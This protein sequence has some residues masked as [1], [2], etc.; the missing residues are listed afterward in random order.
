MRNKKTVLLTNDD[1]FH[2]PGIKSLYD[3]FSKD[4]DVIAVAPDKEQSGVGHTFTF[5][6][7]LHYREAL[8]GEQMPGYL[9]S[10]SPAD[11]VKFAISFLLP[12]RPDIVI[13]GMN[14]GDNS[15]LS[16]FYSGTVAAAREGAFWSIPSFAFSMCSGG[17]SY[18]NQYAVT[19][20]S[21]VKKILG[22]SHKPLD[23]K[24]Y[25][26]VNFPACD[27]KLMK[28]SIVTWQSMAY[29]D[30]RY[31]KIEVETHQTK[32]GYLV[33]G[34]KKDIENT[35]AFDSR[36]LMNNFTTITPLTFDSTAHGEIPFLRWLEE[37]ESD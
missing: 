3:V 2:A 6:K 32:E 1:G 4:Y 15:G 31:E 5:N 25:Y 20:C 16:A 36:A 37:S 7:P 24:I 14:D 33:Y 12:V 22:G 34:E 9:V 23:P 18:A 8:D 11:C 27:P 17:M 28:G 10:G 21:I 26:N 29:F 19:A 30:D 13:S 35:N